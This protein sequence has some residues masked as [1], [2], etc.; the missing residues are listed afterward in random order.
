MANQS[1]VI[2][3][4]FTSGDIPAVWYIFSY[5]GRL[6][7]PIKKMHVLNCDHNWI[8]S[9]EHGNNMI[10]KVFERSRGPAEGIGA[11]SE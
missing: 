9:D 8:C 5:F 11:R 1:F 6:F 7:Q 4:Q 2:R 3:V 10:L